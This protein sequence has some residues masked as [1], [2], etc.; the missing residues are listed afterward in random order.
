MSLVLA[1][2]GVVVLALSGC[3][4]TAGFS[5]KSGGLAMFVAAFLGGMGVCLTPC[6]YP[7]IPITV[8]VFGGMGSSEEAPGKRR[9]RAAIS[10]V[11]YVLGIAV[12][13]STLGLIAGLA[14]RQ[15]VGDHLGAWYVVVPLAVLFLAMAASMF[16]AFELALPASLQT[17]LSGVGGSGVLGGFLMGLVAGLIAAPCTGPVI[18]GILAFI[19]SSQDAFLGFWLLFTFSMGMG[20]MFFLIAA[21]ASV[22]PRSGNWMEGV[23]SVFGVL[24]IVAALYYLS[25]LVPL[26]SAVR[27]RAL[28]V[29]LTGAGL[30][31]LGAAVGGVHL[32]FHDHRASTWARKLGGVL[33]L[34]AG[35]FLVLQWARGSDVKLQY[36][37]IP[38]ALAAAKESRRPLLMDFWATWCE[39]CIELEK[40]TLAHPKVAAELK[41]RFITVKVDCSKKNDAVKKIK[42]DWGV[43]DLPTLVLVS[44][45]GQRIRNL[46]G[47]VSPAELLRAL[48][49][50]R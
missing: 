5:A 17:R 6:V 26:L 23:K 2:L 19:A 32:S 35:I 36:T 21:F 3:D 25:G 38:K 16:G 10:G 22:M 1:A 24:M 11:M 15:A 29:V 27:V 12:T 30:I 33:A 28:W 45:D 18:T 40:E 8:S 47:K 7:L 34:V 41:R 46:V 48:E 43:K 37:S 44:P 20:L 14:G 50:I 4:A 39:S 42:A 9:L 31:V 49:P 13:Y